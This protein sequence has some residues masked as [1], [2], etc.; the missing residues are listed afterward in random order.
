VLTGAG[1]CA[2]L[3]TAAA[4]PPAPE[5][6][7]WD[8]WTIREGLPQNSITDSMQATDHALWVTTFGGLA[9]F[10]GDRFEVHD[11]SADPGLDNPRFMSVLERSDGTIW[12]GVQG[13][14]IVRF[15]G[16]R[17]ARVP[18]PEAVENAFVES[19]VEDHNGVLWAATWS[20][21]VRIGAGRTEVFGA[22]DGLPV[23]S[24]RAVFIDSEDTLWVGSGDGALCWAGWNCPPRQPWEGPIPKGA[25]STFGFAQDAA[26][27]LWSNG[28]DGL[29]RRDGDAWTLVVPVSPE[30]SHYF[31]GLL[32]T[33]D[34]SL[35]FSDGPSLRVRTGDGEVH[36]IPLRTRS[37]KRNRAPIRS[38]TR[39]VGGSIWVGT[40][41]EGLIRVRDR[42]VALHVPSTV[43]SPSVRSVLYDEARARVWLGAGCQKLTWFDGETFDAIPLPMPGPG[44]VHALAL[45]PDGAL[46]MGA[47]ER[48][49]RWDE[50]GIQPIDEGTPRATISALLF[51][52]DGSLLLGTTRGVYRFDGEQVA[53]AFPGQQMDNL[54]VRVMA[55]GPRD[56]LWLGTTEGLLMAGPQGLQTLQGDVA[57]GTVR[58]IHFDD[59]GTAWL[60][61]Y[62]GGLT[63]IREGQVTRYTRA[64]GLCD[65]VVSR[66]LDDGRGGLWMNGNRGLFRVAREDFDALDDGSGELLRCQL[67]E[68]GEGNG[69]AWPAGWRSADGRLWLPTVHGLVEVDPAQITS[70][71]TP[72][73]VAIAEITIGGHPIDDAHLSAPAGSGDLMVRYRGLS[74]APLEELRFRHRLVGYDGRWIEQ[75]TGRVA[76]Y[77]NLPPGNYTF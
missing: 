45:G 64:Q 40:D 44:C 74:L 10:D 31:G 4:R 65:D 32:A 60:G 77:L 5:Q 66:I 39:D 51:E 30:A 68:S 1:L 57:P 62:G 72:P 17:F 3:A 29:S 38:L 22:A 19:L 46:W 21:L 7:I 59:D 58:D 6:F 54:D 23:G 70:E 33:P 27:T 2:L 12:L 50:E 13:G 18:L 28:I 63:R 15:D 67:L 56:R 34:G 24:A 48:L 71:P 8:I 25:N 35:W 52:P 69:G 49:N 73:R 61:T 11:M 76:S 43:S 55:F 47:G 14:G 16:E 42:K 26:G 75:G 53:P 20:G 36:T 37:G 9:R 41:G